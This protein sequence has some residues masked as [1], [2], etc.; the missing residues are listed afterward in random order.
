MDLVHL[1]SALSSCSNLGP[2][3]CAVSVVVDNALHEESQ[4]GEDE[5]AV[6]GVVGNGYDLCLEPHAIFSGDIQ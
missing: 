2:V 6:A 4:C 5:R 1:L 3:V